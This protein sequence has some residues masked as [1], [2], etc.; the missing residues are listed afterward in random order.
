MIESEAEDSG[1]TIELVRE[2]YRSLKKND[3]QKVGQLAT[4][5]KI[6][7]A[8]LRE[9][10]RD[11][12]PT[13]NLDIE[14][15]GKALIEHLLNFPREL[16]R[17]ETLQVIYDLSS[18]VGKTYRNEISF[19]D[20][21]KDLMGIDFDKV[22][23]TPEYFLGDYIGYRYTHK[24]D[25]ARFAFSIN[26]DRNYKLTRFNNKYVGRAGNLRETNG[27][28]YAVDGR[29]YLI[30]QVSN[31]VAL[32][33]FVIRRATAGAPRLHG[34]VMT[35]NS[36]LVLLAARTAFIP[37][38]AHRTINFCEDY[39]KDQFKDRDFGDIPLGVFP[40]DLIEGECS[41]ATIE[42]TKYPSIKE[43]LS[44]NIREEN[45]LRIRE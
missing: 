25:I 41:A 20:A 10:I 38:E 22:T 30:G 26:Y 40:V 21:L 6:D 34:L 42:N 44:N 23:R 28:G 18:A 5:A 29:L 16:L 1:S 12:N 37:V 8:K 14:R 35:F 17:K 32:E 9:F 19:N 15:E 33:P 13:K 3:G 43:M 36:E 45:V 2:A 7:A 24:G 31:N 39:Y 27:I 11:E 4:G